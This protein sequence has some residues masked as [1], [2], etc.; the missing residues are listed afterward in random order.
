MFCVDEFGPL[1]LQ[2]YPGQQWAVTGGG[3]SKVLLLAGDA[4]AEVMRSV[5]ARLAERFGPFLRVAD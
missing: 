5:D 1:N 3:G 2:P 4:S